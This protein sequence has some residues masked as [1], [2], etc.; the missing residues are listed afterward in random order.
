MIIIDITIKYNIYWHNNI[1]SPLH[2]FLQVFL[3]LYSPTFLHI[4]LLIT[5]IGM[6]T[7]H[8]SRKITIYAYFNC[9]IIFIIPSFNST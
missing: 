7:I 3:G 6:G 2:T 4:S 9:I 1:A 8:P 5:S